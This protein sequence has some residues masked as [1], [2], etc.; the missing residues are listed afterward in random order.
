MQALLP[1]REEKIRFCDVRLMA[2]RAL[3]DIPLHLSQLVVH[4]HQLRALLS[5]GRE[6]RGSELLVQ[7]LVRRIVSLV[8]L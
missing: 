7:L 2:Q 4:L 3:R 5:R 1:S 8:L 6:W